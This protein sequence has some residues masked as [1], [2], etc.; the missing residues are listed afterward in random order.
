MLKSTGYI[1]IG[2]IH[3]GDNVF[4]SKGC[5][6]LPGTT[7]G[8]NVIIGAGAVIAKDIPDNVVV[9]GNPPRVLYSYDE[10]IEKHKRLM[11]DGLVV[12]SSEYKT[13]EVKEKVKK[14]GFCYIRKR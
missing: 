3:I 5:I 14:K 6:I 8:S 12:T 11:E 1:K 9:V 10:F 4:I 2:K 7:I 13:V